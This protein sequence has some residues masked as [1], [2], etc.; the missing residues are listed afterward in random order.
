MQEAGEAV[1]SLGYRL[2]AEQETKMRTRGGWEKHTA[3]AGSL[4]VLVVLLDE[5]E[6]GLVVLKSHPATPRFALRLIP[7]EFVSA[8]PIK[9]AIGRYAERHGRRGRCCR[10]RWTT[11]VP[12]PRAQS[13]GSRRRAADRG[14]GGSSSTR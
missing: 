6:N 4:L 13:G 12:A 7:N 1:I 3:S 11:C 10:R 8:E 9:E 5:R 14:E 2:D